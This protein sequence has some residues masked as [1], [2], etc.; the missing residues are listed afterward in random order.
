[1]PNIQSAAKRMRQNVKRRERN[2]T[3][4]AE[5]RTMTKKAER[6]IDAGQLDGARTQLPATLSSIGKTAQKG[7]IH[8]NKAARLASRLTRRLNALE[9]KA[10]A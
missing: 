4:R 9:N 6:E 7:L 2:R 8:K 10:K 1:M 5:M 3:Q